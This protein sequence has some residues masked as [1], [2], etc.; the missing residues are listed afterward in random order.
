[1]LLYIAVTIE[2][3]KLFRFAKIADT[4]NKECRYLGTALEDES[5][6]VEEELGPEVCQEPGLQAPFRFHHGLVQPIQ[7]LRQPIFNEIITSICKQ[8]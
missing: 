6:G 2:T 7:D 8:S 1:L 3:L 5:C 4:R